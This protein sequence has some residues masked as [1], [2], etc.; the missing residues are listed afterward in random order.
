LKFKANLGQLQSERS[1]FVVQI[2]K[3]S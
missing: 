1:D 2:R 3:H